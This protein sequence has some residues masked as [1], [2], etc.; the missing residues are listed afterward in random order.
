MPGAYLLPCAPRRRAAPRPHGAGAVL[1]A[2]GRARRRRRAR[3]PAWPPAGVLAPCC[4]SGPAL[5]AGRTHDGGGAWRLSAGAAAATGTGVDG[6]GKQQQ[7]VWFCM[8]SAPGRPCSGR[9]RMDRRANAAISVTIGNSPPGPP[10]APGPPTPPPSPGAG[11]V[12]VQLTAMPA[13]QKPPSC[14]TVHSAQ[15]FKAQV[16]G[17]C[18]ALCPA[19]RFAHTESAAAGQL[20]RR[21][22]QRMPLHRH[23]GEHMQLCSGPQLC[24]MARKQRLCSTAH[25]RTASRAPS[26]PAW[27]PTRRA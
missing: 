13:A 27:L 22:A 16:R 17:P 18:E 19:P 6:G 23:F 4:K 15:T 20:S 1:R 5:V 11:P 21:P 2:R 10:P 12:D 26:G 8:R 7:P 14:T 24:P 9:V 3:A 25:H